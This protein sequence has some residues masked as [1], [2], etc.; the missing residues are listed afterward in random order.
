M[1]QNKKK[2][3]Y[4]EEKPLEMFKEMLPGTE[5]KTEPKKQRRKKGK[6]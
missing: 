5:P 4:K 6:I 2:V 1:K 3:I